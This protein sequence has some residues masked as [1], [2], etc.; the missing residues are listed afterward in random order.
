MAAPQIMRLTLED[1]NHALR[2]I[3]SDIQKSSS[4]GKAA[5]VGSVPTV[6]ISVGGGASSG[7]V[8][9]TEEVTLGIVTTSRDGTIQV[10]ADGYA[11]LEQITLL[12]P[13]P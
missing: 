12:A 5:S 7:D 10:D 6:A 13:E 4:S 3:S 2:R 8:A 11:I 1:V 9:G